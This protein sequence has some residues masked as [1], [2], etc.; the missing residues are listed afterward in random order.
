MSYEVRQGDCL[1]IM[2]TLQP[3]SVDAVVTDPPYGLAFMG[4]AWDHGVPGVPFWVEALRVAK[5]GAHLVAFGGTRTHHRLTCAIEDA[6]WEIRDCLCWL[7]GSGFPK[8]LDV[9]KAI[10]K[11]AGAERTEVIGTRHRNVKPFDDVAGWNANNTTGDHEYTAPATDAARQWAGWGTALKPAYEPIIVARKPL[12]GTVAANVLA[13]GTGALNVDGCRIE[14]ADG[15]AEN[16]VTQ[17]VNTARTSWEPRQERRTFAPSQVGRWP[18][19]VLLDEAAAAMLDEQSGERPGPGGPAPNYRRR[20]NGVTGFGQ[21]G[22]KQGVVCPG[23]GG[24]AS[25]FFYTS[26]SSSGERHYAGRNAHPTV[27]PVDLMRW[28]CR[29]VT[30]PGGL[31]LDPFCGSG[32]TGIAALAEGFR[33][34]GCE[35]NAEYVALAR[36]RIAGPLFAEE[37]TA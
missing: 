10:D 7:Y 31:I 17:G 33:F 11:A 21:A 18:A 1:E 26:K 9:S 22:D 25:R 24:G 16:A 35:L 12:I 28:L 23:E 8:S 4:K 37:P 3:D 13:H 19:N 6:G 20:Q 27:K 5:P 32:S 15:Y 2:R 29:L 14:T 36:K 34:I 30:P